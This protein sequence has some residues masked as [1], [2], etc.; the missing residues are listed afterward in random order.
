MI[1]RESNPRHRAEGDFESDCADGF[2][3]VV[4][5]SIKPIGFVFT[6]ELGDCEPSYSSTAQIMVASLDLA[7]VDR[8]AL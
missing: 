1:N 5:E 4:R 2:G 8:R 6:S 3:C 7:D